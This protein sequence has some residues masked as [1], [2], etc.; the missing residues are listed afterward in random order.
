MCRTGC[1]TYSPRLW[2]IACHQCQ[3]RWPLWSLAQEAW[4]HVPW[5]TR[6]TSLQASIRSELSHLKVCFLYSQFH[7]L[8]TALQKSVSKL[9]IKSMGYFFK[10]V[11]SIILSISFNLFYLM[12]KTCFEIS[13]VLLRTFNTINDAKDQCE[14][15]RAWKVYI[16]FV[17]DGRMILNT[18]YD[19]TCPTKR[20]AWQK[21]IPTPPPQKGL[22]YIAQMITSLLLVYYISSYPTYKYII[23]I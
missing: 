5:G 15:E 23:Y 1:T 20:C 4:A 17:M 21:R 18:Y 3:I 9:S 8:L 2:L 7:C 10:R 11:K 13:L 12:D 19:I 22:L 6:P 16:V 14:T